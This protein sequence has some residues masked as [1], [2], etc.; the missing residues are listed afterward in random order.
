MVTDSHNTSD[1]V[2]FMASI[3]LAV[4]LFASMAGAQ[5]FTYSVS[6]SPANSGTLTGPTCKS[7]TAVN[8]TPIG[9]CTPV[10]APGFAFKN[11]SSTGCDYSNG[12]SAVPSTGF[13]LDCNST[14]TGNFVATT[15]AT[16]PIAPTCATKPCIVLSCTPSPQANATST[17]TM[18]RGMGSA[19]QTQ[20]AAG[21][22]NNCAYAD[23]AVSAGNSYT[24]SAVAVVNGQPSADSNSFTVTIPAVVTLTTPTV[25]IVFSPATA[26]AATAVTVTVS[27]NATGTVILSSGAYTSA[28]ATLTNGVATIQIPGGTLDVG[29]I[30]ITA[31]YTP[32]AAGAS[33]YNPATAVGSIVITPTSPTAL[34]GATG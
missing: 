7:M 4:L 2:I 11:W 27:V 6:V 8:G 13:G 10:P 14:I 15:S 3:I 28:S 9:A 20:L 34:S 33:L 30:S 25:S 32:D 16:P 31:T 23:T 18:M 1:R 29:S 21:L 12:G 24:Y 17:V 19:A 22:P 26:D 5:T